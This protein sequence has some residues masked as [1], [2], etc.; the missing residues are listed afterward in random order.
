MSATAT[1]MPPSATTRAGNEFVAAHTDE[2]ATL[3][4]RMAELVADP[5]ALLRAARLGFAAFADGEFRD[6]LIRVAPGI[7]PEQV[8]GVRQ[9][10]MEA[11]HRAY[12]KGRRHAPAAQLLD[13]A[14]RLLAAEEI[15]LR[16]LGIWDL[17]RPL[18][19]EPERTWRHIRQAAARATEWIT[20]D[21]L[22]HPV[23]DGILLDGARWAELDRLAVSP[24]RW[25]RRL[26]GSTLATMPY[27]KGL[28]GAKDAATVAKALDYLTD[29]MGD[30][31][32][33]VQMS[34]SWTLRSC[35]MVDQPA[36]IA[37][38]EQEAATAKA[39][40]DGHRAWVIRDSLRKIPA[41]QAAAVK[42]TI[43][44]IRRRKGAPS[45]SRAATTA[46]AAPARATREE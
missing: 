18:A 26:V 31:E 11:L 2:A 1:A 43:E 41:A 8:V 28:P 9:P 7:D 21:T 19:A 40:D 45:T 34:L 20:I 38:L 33:T 22:A 4:G 44:G 6:G 25:E 42:Q 17:A 39:T 13:A 15:E 36:V 10:L 35:A 37:F 5:E 32:E 46:A 29:L 3:G 14:A 12:K 24:S 16:W 23:R 30:N 27:A